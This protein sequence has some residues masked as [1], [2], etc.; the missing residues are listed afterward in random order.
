MP[1][2]FFEKA[3]KK[4]LNCRLLQIIGGTLRANIVLSK[5]DVNCCKQTLAS[6]P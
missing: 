6:L 3:A 5:I 1:E 4:K 2:L